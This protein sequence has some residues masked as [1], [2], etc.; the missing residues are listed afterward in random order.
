[1]YFDAHW[2]KT[3]HDLS[4]L[5]MMETINH[6]LGPMTPPLSSK[7]ILTKVMG[8]NE[9]VHPET[10]AKA[11]CILHNRGL[12]RAGGIAIVAGLKARPDD[13]LLKEDHRLLRELV[14][15]DELSPIASLVSLAQGGV[16][17]GSHIITPGD[18]GLEINT[19]AVLLRNNAEVIAE[20]NKLALSGKHTE[21]AKYLALNAAL[22]LTAFEDLPGRT[23]FTRNDFLDSLRT[24]TTR[25]LEV[26]VSGRASAR[27]D[28]IAASF[29]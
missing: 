2:C 17:L 11:Y 9:K 14:V 28:K 1:L 29:R 15:L 26:V 12:Q 19:D 16:F 20:A 6:V 10:I 8:V 3:I 5:L 24:S 18:V 4:H 7:A 27:R 25:C 23:K 22:G 21:L 13:S